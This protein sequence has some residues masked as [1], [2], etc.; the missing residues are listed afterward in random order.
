MGLI[1]CSLLIMPISAQ[2]ADNI[3]SLVNASFQTSW[4]SSCGNP[5]ANVPSGWYIVEPTSGA[6]ANW[7]LNYV[8]TSDNCANGRPSD[9]RLKLDQIYGSN[10][11]HNFVLGKEIDWG[12]YTQATVTVYYACHYWSIG[13]TTGQGKVQLGVKVN[14]QATAWSDCGSNYVQ[15]VNPSECSWGTMQITVSKGSSSTFTVMLNGVATNSGGF[16]CQ[17]DELTVTGSTGCTPPANPGSATVNGATCSTLNVAN[18]ASDSGTPYY[19]FR[20]NGGSYTNQYI[21][22]NGSVGSSAVW[23]TKATWGTKT[24]TGLAANTTYAFDVI[25]ANDSSGTCPSSYSSVAQGTTSALASTPGVPTVNGATSSSLNVANNASDSSSAYF[26]IR[27]NGGSYSNYYVQSNG[28]VGASAV[29]Q[30]KAT[31]GTKTVT[32]LA[33]STTYTFD[34]I[35]ASDGSGNCSSGFGTSAQGTTSCSPPATPGAPTVTGATCSSINVANNASDSGTAYFAFRINGGSYS[36]YYVQG[37]GSVGASPVWQTK[38]IWGTK[39]V[40]GLAPGTNYTFTVAAANDGAGSCAT[41]YGAGTA[42]TTNSVP[43]A[44]TGGSGTANSAAQITWGWT[45]SGGTGNTYKVYDAAT[46]GN[47]KATSNVDA[48]SVAETGLSANT[49]YSRWVDANNTCGASASR[50]ALPATYTL[51]NVP[52]APTVNAPTSSTLNVAVNANGNPAATTFSIKCVGSSTLYVQ[53]DGSLGATEVFQ[54]QA[55]WGTK[56]VT[57]LSSNTTYTFSVSAKN[58]AGVQ[59]AYGATASGTTTATSVLYNQVNYVLSASGSQVRA[60]HFNPS[61]AYAGSIPSSA[62]IYS[63]GFSVQTAAGESVTFNLALYNWNTNYSTTIGGT[64]IATRTGIVQSGANT[65]WQTLSLSTPIAANADY[66]LVMTHTSFTGSIGVGMERDYPGPWSQGGSQEAWQNGVFKSDRQFN[67]Q[68]LYTYSCSPPSVPGAPTVDGATCG[69][70]NVTNNASDSSSASFAF[71]VNGGGY[72]NKYVQADGTVGSTPVWQTKAAWGTRTVTGLSSST[73][74]TFDVAAATDSSGSCASSYGTSANGTTS[75]VASTP[76]A[77]T[78]NSPSVSTLNFTNNASDSSSAYFAIRI[79]GGGYSNQYVQA[80]GTVNSS[81]VWQTKATWA[82][83][84]VSGLQANTT[85]TFDVKAANDSAGGCASGFGPTTQGTTSCTTLSTPGAPTVNGA[86]STTLNVANNSGDSGSAYF[87][88]RI[89]GGGYSNQYVQGDG[90]VGANAV[91]QLKAAWGTKTVTGLASSTTY[92]FDV[93]AATDS[94]GSCATGF[95]TS[96]QGTTTG[97]CGG[98]TIGSLV[99][100]CFATG[101]TYRSGGVPTAPSGWTIGDWA[102]TNGGCMQ[103]T[104]SGDCA[105]GRPTDHRCKFEFGGTGQ[106]SH[107]MIYKEVSWGSA[108]SVTITVAASRHSWGGSGNAMLAVKADGCG[109]R[110]AQRT[111]Q[112]YHT[113]GECTWQ[114]LSLSVTR[115]AGAST[116]TVM[117]NAH[118]GDTTQW[119]CQFDNLQI[120]AGANV[121]T[122]SG[123]IKSGGVNL[124]GVT[125]ATTSGGFTATTDSNGNYTF[126]NVPPGTYTMTATKAGYTQVTQTGVT[127]TAGNATTQNF[128]LTA[129]A[130]TGTLSG[131]VKSI[132]NQPISGATI[133]TSPSSSTT[134]TAADGSFTLSGVSPGTYTVYASKSLYQTFGRTNQVVQAS[135]TTTVP[136]YYLVTSGSKIGFHFDGSIAYG[137]SDL[138]TRLQNANI[139]L[140]IKGL[141]TFGQ[142]A[143]AKS[144]C[145]R[146][147]TVGRI[148]SLPNYGNIKGL[149]ERAKPFDDPKVVAQQIYNEYKTQCFAPNG[150]NVDVWEVCNEWD[151]QYE[152][153]AEFY[154]AF[155]DLAEADG[156]RIALWS[157]STG[158]PADS[159]NW[160]YL[161]KACKRAKAHGGHVM[162]THEYQTQAYPGADG[163]MEYEYNYETANNLAHANITHYRD[164]YNY[165]AANNADIPWCIT[166]CGPQAGCAQMSDHDMIHDM[167]FYDGLL[168]QDAYMAGAGIYDCGMAGADIN[169]TKTG[170]STCTYYGNWMINGQL[171]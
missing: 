54:T 3:G 26:A 20:I 118:P 45:L 146:S 27:I 89:N 150:S 166:E 97:S 6:P 13:G 87:A 36:N 115:P 63:V 59:T 94:N 68:L 51:A 2:A 67:V 21:Q 38:A 142:C 93:K 170:S 80:N 121:G 53:A 127:V 83:K 101:W 119:N 15:Q 37:N 77:P 16:N 100:P 112:V 129:G 39:T 103:L 86:T 113:A 110:Y 60:Q 161:A 29:W 43:A 34:V 154:I 98:E 92:T 8:T 4:T 64:P 44:P 76:G 137:F 58:G 148:D 136:T 133:S 62:Q 75:A 120:T 96:A 14:G 30:T 84:T 149:D 126:S 19:A 57:G 17:F 18:N 95:G 125:V 74:Y 171:P 162:A 28:S 158:S 47:L 69:T 55:T 32:G 109:T 107:N 122:I 130:S 138:C 141:G 151:G 25:A 123:N 65:V 132:T 33:A 163:T 99:N 46:G 72:T 153:Q 35:A 157:C 49:Q 167:A 124:S 140:Y 108:G 134:T 40:T 139:P 61:T 144:A 52:S 9:H 22:A 71:R 114:T 164:I 104:T 156:Y 78:I 88:I 11:N 41:S 117:L 79:N 70:L 50:L 1:V 91:W 24:V 31:W 5:P 90:T 135:L 7:C 56:T 111:A 165:L 160:V 10:A 106:M 73:T 145:S 42:G 12:S 152:W 82:T 143:S 155:M 169:Y 105:S 168:M 147:F 48:S 81:A 102:A 128:T 66:M 159:S 23:Q 131:V 85:Y 116:F